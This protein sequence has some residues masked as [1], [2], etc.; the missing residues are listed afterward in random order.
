MLLK[1]V[2]NDFKRQKSIS[3]TL[4]IFIMLAALLVASGSGMIMKLIDSIDQLFIEADAPHFVQMHAGSIDQSEID[5]F[6]QSID[7]VEGQQTVTMLNVDGANVQIGENEEREINSVMDTSFVTQN[8]AFD[9]LLGLENE[10]I[11]VNPGE[12]GVPIYYKQRDDLNIGE[13]VTMSDG[14][15]EM[16]FTITHFVRD[17]LMNPS[18][19][20]SK[21]FL[22]HEED[23]NIVSQFAE[24]EYL[25]EF[26]LSD[27][28][29][30]PDFSQSY[31]AAQLPNSGPT[32]D[33]Q[34][35][36]LLNGLTDGIVAVVVI[37]VSLLLIVI[38]SLCLRLT[39]QATIEED[40][41]EIGVM[42]AIGL[43]H[44]YMLKL[45]LTKYIVMTVIACL[46][47]Y[48]LSFLLSPL[49]TENIQVYAGTSNMGLLESL[50]P[51]VSVGVIGLLVILFCRF[52]LRRLNRISAVQAL[53]ASSEGDGFKRGKK[54]LS[55]SKSGYTP[56]NLFLGFRDLVIRFKVYLLLFIIFIISS[57]I[58]IVPVNF[59]N[60]IHSHQFISY[61]GIGQ[62]DIRIDLQRSDDTMERLNDVVTYLENDEEVD[63]YAV[64]MTSQFQVLNEEEGT[65][66]NLTIETGDLSQFPLDYLDGRE[67][68]TEDE[69][70][71]SYLNSQDLEKEVGDSLIVR[72]EN[73]VE[74]GLNVSGIYQD[75]T[76]GGRTAKGRL[77]A[78]EDRV[79]WYVISVDLEEHV[80]IQD[81][82][83]EYTQS[84]HPT[85][86][87]HLQDYLQQTLGDTMEQLR[88][89]TIVAIF[90]G[91]FISI[92]ITTLFIKML[93]AKDVRQNAIMR[94]IGF[95]I[96]DIRQQYISRIVTVM[97][98]G[99]TVGTLISN[100][101][102]QSLVSSIWSFMGASKIEFVIDPIQAY[103]IFPIML[104][105]CVI[106]TTV[107]A[108]SS[109]DQKHSVF[110]D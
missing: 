75:I 92:L 94:S 100:K 109:T 89:L 103:I 95:S 60:T 16:D 19:V 78:N 48:G 42:K 50:I 17:A 90:I 96:K 11:H 28:S 3:V 51:I 105:S 55:L 77:S 72:T 57:F 97:V 76:N 107:I 38:A 74:Y 83:S 101:I 49:F 32:I 46:V 26:Q 31:Q 62:S 99:I 93:L 33:Y 70:A 67:P 69:L 98:I 9:Y 71:L 54:L 22:V 40:Y 63:K 37:L 104:L 91:L 13:S 43:R 66:D 5:Q 52:T 34:S 68:S 14:T 87:T 30:L 6:A 4:M 25:I 64:Y 1:M 58:I 84:F 24:V 102:G 27:L 21:R 53:R 45:F 36:Q 59:Y 39:I 18:V 80:V 23:Y 41:H 79:L 86:V 20:H 8:E 65:F 73:G 56:V 35:F 85:K 47:G 29:Y 15:T 88:M 110:R 12:I 2:R 81:K 106:V 61:M 44:S 7:Y 82:V 10:R 108:T